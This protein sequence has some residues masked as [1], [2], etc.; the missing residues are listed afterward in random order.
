M[1]SNLCKS[2]RGSAIVLALITTA[3]VTTV[4]SAMLVW[5]WQLA[6]VEA[7]DRQRAQA[8]W[9]LDGAQQWSR[10]ILRQ[11]AQAD[12]RANR[13][14]DHAAEPWAMTL[15]P[16]RLDAFLAAA[17][18]SAT[19]AATPLAG[20][21]SSLAAAMLSGQIL[22]ANA[23]LNLLNFLYLSGKDAERAR[24]QVRTLFTA[25]NLPTTQA[26]D[27]LQRLAT[28]ADARNAQRVLLPTRLADLHA[29]GLPK[30]SLDT[31][32]PYVWLWPAA[33]RVN[34]NTASAPVLQALS[35]TQKNKY[36]QQII[37][38]RRQNAY[39]SVEAAFKALGNASAQAFNAADLS[40]RSDHFIASGIVQLEAHR[41]AW[42]V[43]AALERQDT[44]VF[45]RAQTQGPAASLAP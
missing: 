9:L 33:M 37:E 1:K 45:T 24:T 11:D 4:A 12:R 30:E 34:I 28:V 15:R 36:V 18:A 38:N 16:T 44:D 43:Q 41:S 23:R 21:D 26:D 3:L 40:V 25:L 5:Q 6:Q 31:L 32:A 17:Q 2:Q 29:L 39:S 8:V 42:Q 14:S 27:L 13:L 19:Q 22:D 7:V 20:Q 10:L 35:Q